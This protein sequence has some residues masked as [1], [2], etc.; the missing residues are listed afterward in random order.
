MSKSTI[1]ATGVT[2][3]IGAVLTGAGEFILHFDTFARFGT[4]YAFFTGISP[5]GLLMAPVIHI[6]AIRRR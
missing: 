3:L 1:F 6:F 4:E 5:R 2:G